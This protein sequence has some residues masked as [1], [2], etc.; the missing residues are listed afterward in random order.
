MAEIRARLSNSEILR[1]TKTE[2][3]FSYFQLPLT[4]YIFTLFIYTEIKIDVAKENQ[5]RYF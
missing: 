2:I 1:V 3:D 4:L 5:I